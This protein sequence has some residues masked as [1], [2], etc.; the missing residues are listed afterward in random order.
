MVAAASEFDRALRVNVKTA[1]AL[2]MLAPLIVMTAPLPGTFFPFIVGKALYAR[3]LIEIAFGLWVVLALRSPSNRAPRS[4]L[5]P[6]FA[7]YVLVVLLASLLGVSPQRSLWSTYER[8]QG[9]VDLAHWF[10]FTWVLASVFR[11]WND[12]R[13]LLNFNLG[14]SA[15]MGLLGLGQHY[16][17]GL[18]VDQLSYLKATT[19]LDI[20]L[21]NAT[22]VGAYMMVNVLIGLGFLA[23]SFLRPAIPAPSRPAERRRSR[24]RRRPKEEQGISPEMAWVA[25]WIAAVTAGA[26]ILAINGAWSIIIALAVGLVAV[27]LVTRRGDIPPAWRVFWLTMIVLASLSHFLIPYSIKLLADVSTSYFSD[28]LD[29]MALAAWL[30]ALRLAYVKGDRRE[31]LWRLF[32]ISA[33]VLYAL[34]LYLSVTRGAVAGLVGGV[35][36]VATGYAIWGRVRQL[37]LASLV[38]VGSVLALALVVVMV[39]DTAGFERIAKSNPL[40]H[41]VFILFQ[42]DVSLEGRIDSAAVGLKGFAARPLLGWG[43]ENFTIAYDRYVTQEIVAAA[44]TS[45]D[46][47]HNKPIEELTT[48]GIM[49]LLV[50]M[51]LWL[52]MAAVVA[53]TA[54]HQEAQDQL[55]TLFAGGA[56]AGYFV[57]NL[58]LFDTPGTGPQFYLLLGFIIYLDTA[59]GTANQQLSSGGEE[60]RSLLQSQGSLVGALAITGIL[61]AL[62][63]YQFNYR[64]FESSSSI[65]RLLDSSLSWQQRLDKFDQTVDSF[66]QLANY[67]RIVMF[68]Q[69]TRNWGSL[70][71]QEAGAAL[72]AVDR[73][74]RKGIAS[75]P[76]EWRLYLS[77][78]SLYHRAAPADQG[79]VDRARSLV[80]EATELAPVRIETVQMQVQQH[81]VER[82]YA[83]AL[84]IIDGYLEKTPN[85]ARYLQGLRD[86]V[87]KAS[88]E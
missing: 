46:Q 87:V 81:V 8:M 74:G 86:Q 65:L 3:T 22:Y 42:G 71:P 49:G 26:F 62:T 69:L 48:K 70:N 9:F 79:Y 47:A 73:E 19:R 24:R 78:A 10:A 5:L 13:W 12:W 18:I 16:Q 88:G 45:F 76:E 11:S 61:V 44:V 6:I 57:Q 39:R 85:A 82:N 68:N 52:Y 20:T 27:T 37:R 72:A 4:R 1:I 15:F 7:L 43:P 17:F 84:G 56:L 2:T 51:G 60:G 36:A 58:F 21:G 83:A 55:F 59:A 80:E 30:V 29:L 35:M 64:A 28:R 25:L 31:T 75:E 14:V 23:R 66:P 32:W 40:L 67:P 34:I 63:I 41:R 53:R 50:Y 38:L 77:V 54:K 33:V